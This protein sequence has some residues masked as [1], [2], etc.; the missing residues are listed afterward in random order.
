MYSKDWLYSLSIL[1]NAYFSLY[2]GRNNKRERARSSSSSSSFSLNLYRTTVSCQAY[3][4]ARIN[5]FIR[6]FT[7]FKESNKWKQLKNAMNCILHFMILIYKQ[8]LLRQYLLVTR[9]WLSCFNSQDPNSRIRLALSLLSNTVSNFQ[10]WQLN[11]ELTICSII[12]I[13]SH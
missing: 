9:R 8:G 6:Q 3:N 5:P 2:E 4:S 1:I 11:L 12:W 7:I 10:S 13:T